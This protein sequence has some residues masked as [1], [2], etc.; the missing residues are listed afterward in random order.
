MSYSWQVLANSYNG[1]TDQE[2]KDLFDGTNYIH[3]TEADLRKLGK[4][5]VLIADDYDTKH[6]F[7]IKAVPQDQ[8][9]TP[10]KLI[11]VKGVKSIDNVTITSSVTANSNLRIAVSTDLNKYYA[12]HGSWQE[13]TNLAT[14]GNTPA[15]LASIASADWNT[16]IKDKDG[17][18]FEYFLSIKN[19]SDECSTDKISMQIDMKGSWNGAIR[20]TDY[21]YG[22]SAN[23]QLKVD[24]LKDGSY[25]INYT[26]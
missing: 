7:E 21:K 1:L 20:G 2:K 23:D 12:F 18:A 4:V 16:F 10:K 13:V 26:E 24:L 3:A 11:S 14:D 9:V 8:T 5:K 25:K 15:E 22:Y 19:T 6:K 17:I